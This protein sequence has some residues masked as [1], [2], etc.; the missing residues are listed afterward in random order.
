MGKVRTTNKQLNLAQLIIFINFCLES[1][2]FYFDDRTVLIILQVLINLI[3][4]AFIFTKEKRLEF[5][6]SFTPII[7]ALIV[8]NLA[9]AIFSTDIIPSINKS[10]KFLIPLVYFILGYSLVKSKEDIKVFANFS[11]IYLTYFTLYI[12]IVNIFG[13]GES[14]YANGILK[15]YFS[16][17][18]FYIPCFISIFLIFNFRYVKKSRRLISM[19][20]LFSCVVLFFLFLKRTL[21]LLILISFLIIILKSI[22]N[23]IIT[24]MVSAIA[25]T[26]FFQPIMRLMDSNEKLE[27]RG[28]RFTSE[29]SITNEGRFTENLIVYDLMKDNLFKLLFGTGEVFNDGKYLSKYYETDREAHNSYIRLFWNGGI[30]GL[31]IFLIFYFAQLQGIL[32]YKKRAKEKDSKRIL[33]F[34]FI[35]VL[36]RLIND[37]SSGIT[38]LTYNAYCYLIVGGLIKI[39]SIESTKNIKSR[40]QIEKINESI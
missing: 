21:I 10:F 1:V 37:F 36:L 4:L 34:I 39:G 28:N 20:M 35:F 26:L 5:H 22:K 29:Y 3:F 27:G 13:I 9:I 11:W 14:L 23:L 7:I 17:N 33:L 19:I 16:L 25:L 24:I 31:S 15:G 30:I 40:D 32:F 18:A 2:L 6:K 38:Y 8:Y 12:F